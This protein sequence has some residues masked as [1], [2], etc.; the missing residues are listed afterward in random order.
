M[1]IVGAIASGF[2]AWKIAKSLIT[3]LKSL[4]DIMSKLHGV[5]DGFKILSIAGFLDS[6]FR[7]SEWVRDFIENGPTLD[8]IVGMLSSF[9]GGVGFALSALGHTQLGGVFILIDGL[10]EI[11]LALRDMGRNGANVDNV[12]NMVHGLGN[13]LVAVGFIIKDPVLTGGGF[14]LTGVTNIINELQKNW[15]AIKQGDWSGVDFSILAIGAVEAIG[16]ILVATGKLK[17]IID[18]IGGAKGLA[19]STKAL[20]DTSDAIGGSAGDGLNGS[21]KGLAQNLGWG[22]AIIAEAAAA[23]IIAVGAIWILGEELKK[24]G[25]AWKPVI[26]NAGTVAIAIGIGAGLIAA[27]G[28]AAYGLGTMGAPA[29]INIGIG[30]GILLELGIATGLFLIEI[31]GVGKGLDQ[32]QQAWQ[33]VLDNGEAIATAIGV[34]T[35]LLVGIGVV[36]AALGTATV[37]SAGLL[38]VAIGLGTAILVELAEAFIKF[39]DSLT[40]VADEINNELAPSLRK[41][42]PKLPVLESDMSAF[43]EYM[44]NLSTKISSYSKSMSSIT[45]TSIVNSFIG[46]FKGNPISKLADDVN[47]IYTDTTKLNTKLRAANPELDTAVDLMSN[48]ISLMGQL[49]QLTQSGNDV[50]TL[51]TDMFTNLKVVGEK[52]VTGLITGID[53][54]L[55]EFNRKLENV[56]GNIVRTFESA[57][58]SACDSIQRIIDKLK[59]IPSMNLEIGAE[60]ISTS[61]KAYAKGGFVSSGQL[62]IARE[63]GAEMV[64][65]IGNRAAVANNDQIVAGIAQG[66]YEAVMA[67][68]SESSGNQTIENVMYLDGEVVWKNQQKVARN[69]GYN[70][71]MG[72]FTRA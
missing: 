10:G 28:A 49:Q 62:F 30:T 35:G 29:A 42:N 34:G 50:S 70:F 15:E 44:T 51:A 12:L 32:I 48:Y 61:I 7:F 33:P 3:R 36:T 67:A 63:A 72:A 6:M 23:A 21:L 11:F 54:K 13:V 45:W 37:A 31:W 59:D 66:V 8:N 25:D 39:T 9:S 47:Q 69:R 56:K 17:G 58:T 20:Q 27:I 40:D 57:S 18:K 1:P 64:G 4:K 71:E 41:L 19:D 14:V 38:P 55:P 60:R 43:T 24:V 68:M 65:G 22:V 16:G 53:N 2:L 26:E 46:L 52:L 5:L